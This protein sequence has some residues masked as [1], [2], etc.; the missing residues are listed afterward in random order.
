MRGDYFLTN[1]YPKDV[2]T[3]KEWDCPYCEHGLQPQ[4][5]V[6]LPVWNM[7][8]EEVEYASLDENVYVRLNEYFEKVMQLHRIQAAQRRFRVNKARIQERAR[9]GLW[10]SCCS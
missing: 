1:P 10:T 9:R 3:P 4:R 6:T 8:S 5:M 2:E 7:E